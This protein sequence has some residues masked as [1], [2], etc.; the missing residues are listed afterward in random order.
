MDQKR[1]WKEY[2]NAQIKILEHKSKPIGI[3]NSEPC[4]IEGQKL[5][6]TVDQEIYKRKKEQN[7]QIEEKNLLYIL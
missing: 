1:I 3:D 4:V 7:P 6:L 2:I 5:V